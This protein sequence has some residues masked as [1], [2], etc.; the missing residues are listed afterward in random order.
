QGEKGEQGI[1]GPKGNKGDKGDVGPQGM[2]GPQGEQG[3]KGDKFEYSDFTDEQLEELKFKKDTRSYTTKIKAIAPFDK[4]NITAI[5]NGY[6]VVF[7][8][9]GSLDGDL[10]S[11]DTVIAKIPP[12][13]PYPDSTIRGALLNVSVGSTDDLQGNLYV[14]KKGNLSVKFRKARTGVTDY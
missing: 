11:S 13:V 12:N 4:V 2:P 1:Q 6:S 8:A 14:S 7:N 5:Y 9:E 10:P 3:E